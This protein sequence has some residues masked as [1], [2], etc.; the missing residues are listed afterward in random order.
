MLAL[1]S[2]WN[3]II[4]TLVFFIA[5]GYLKRYLDEQDIP[6]GMTRGA[7]VFTLAFMVAWGA[8]KAADWAQKTIEGPQ[9]VAQISID[10][11]QP[12]NAGDQAPQ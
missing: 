11:S 7:L 4:S 8:G 6:K 2:M 1:P 5:V 3:L 9:P 12:L 10:S